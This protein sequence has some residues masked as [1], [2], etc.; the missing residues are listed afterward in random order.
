MRGNSTIRE[1][2]LLISPEM[3]PEQSLA[4]MVRQMTAK[5]PNQVTE[6]DVGACCAWLEG[7]FWIYTAVGQVSVS[8]L[9]NVIRYAA[10]DENLGVT[11]VIIDNLSVLELEGEDTNRAQA[12]LMTKFVHTSRT[13]RCHIHLVTHCRK[14][15]QGEKPSR[16]NISGSGALSNLADNVISIVRN[17]RKEEQLSDISLDEGERREVSAQYDTM[18]IV[19]KQRH[20]SSYIGTSKLFYSPYSMRWSENRNSPDLAIPEIQTLAEL[21]PTNTRGYGAL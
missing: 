21:G 19:Q 13:S 7:Q 17:E 8:D 3:S 4:R 16:Y 14:P 1:R 15:A 10:A 2:V 5:L 9:N 11:Q 12:S 20:G 18:L 6:A